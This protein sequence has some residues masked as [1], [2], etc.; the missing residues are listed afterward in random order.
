MLVQVCR[1]DRTNTS[2][3]ILTSEE[4]KQCSVQLAQH[5][6]QPCWMMFF[7]SI[8]FIAEKDT[9]KRNASPSLV[10]TFDKIKGRERPENS[11]P[12]QHQSPA[13]GAQNTESSLKPKSAS[14]KQSEESLYKG[15]FFSLLICWSHLSPTKAALQALLQP[16]SFNFLCNS[17]I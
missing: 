12:S 11:F 13:L 1:T 9:G 16:A 6:Q 2:F 15:I 7:P 17:L 14:T 3:R 5:K 8:T 4:Q 10:S